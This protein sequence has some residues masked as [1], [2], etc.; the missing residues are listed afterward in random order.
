MNKNSISQ[1]AKIM[2]ARLKAAD[3]SQL[4]I[5]TELGVSQ[6][7]I[8]RVL[9]GHI[10]RRSRLFEDLCIYAQSKLHG[11]TLSEVKKNQEL[12]SALVDVWDGT[13]QHARSLAQVIRSLAV[14]SSSP[15]APKNRRKSDAM[16]STV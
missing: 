10:K 8:S 4:E 7:Q 11:V 13:A 15:V 3:I 14:L 6:S 2:A 9:S 5:A 12:L 1:E 16:C